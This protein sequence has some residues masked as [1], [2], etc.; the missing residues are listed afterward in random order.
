MYQLLIKLMLVSALAHFGISLLEAE[1]CHS[2]QCVSRLERAS[3]DVL[4]ID[5][6]PISVFPEEAKRFR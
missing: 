5:W 6:K 1:T 2:T 3:H 4:K